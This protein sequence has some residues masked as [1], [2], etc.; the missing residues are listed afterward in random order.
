[1][2]L[3]NAGRPV[4]MSATTQASIG[5]CVLRAIYVSA[6]SSGTLAFHNSVGASAA[7]FTTA[8]LAANTVYELN[9]FFDTAL[10]VVKGG[11]SITATLMVEPI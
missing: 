3:K 4:T 7:A 8:A 9:C 6:S 10:H 2:P 11:T 1:M 5:P